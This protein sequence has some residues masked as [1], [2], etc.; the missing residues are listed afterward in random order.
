MA[1]GYAHQEGEISSDQS[2]TVR[3]GAS[4]AQTPTNT[5]SFWNRYDFTP[6][7]GMGI[8]IIN[9]DDMYAATENVLT[10]AGNVILPGYTR[11]DAAMFMTFNGIFSAQVN[12]E[13]LL[14]KNYYLNAD[15]NNNITPGAP[16]AVRVTLGAK[17]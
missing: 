12:V 17:F 8:G 3:K 7:F 11:V 2:V 13:N 16:R 9:R 10:T 5:F 6:K 14:D 15:N 1:G 4:L